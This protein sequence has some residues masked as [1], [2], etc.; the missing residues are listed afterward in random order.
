MMKWFGCCVL[1]VLLACT[2][3]NDIPTGVLEREKM[4]S[5][6][7]DIIQADQYYREYLI[8][9]SVGK[10]IQQMRYGLYE[11]VFKIHKISRGTF[12]MSYDY[13]SNRPKLMKDIFDSLS[14]S[15][16]RK[17]QD[18]Y[19]PAIPANDSVGLRKLKPRLDSSRAK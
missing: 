1:L 14:A 5:V 12:E 8:R 19:K 11:E 10:N 18:F 4:E 16:N 6:M 2:G 15:G 3:K 9:D 13:Y 17:L 7:W